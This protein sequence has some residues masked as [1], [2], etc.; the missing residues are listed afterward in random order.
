MEPKEEFESIKYWLIVTNPHL[1]L[2]PSEKLSH[3]IILKGGVSLYH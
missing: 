2:F 1:K 3:G